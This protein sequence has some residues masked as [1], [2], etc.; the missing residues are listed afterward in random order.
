MSIYA[1]PLVD[2]LDQESLIPMRLYREHCFSF[3]GSYIKDLSLLGRDMKDVII[4]D[5][6]PNASFFHNENAVP[7]RN[8]S[9]L[10]SSL[11]GARRQDSNPE[12]REKGHKLGRLSKGCLGTER[13]LP[14]YAQRCSVIV[15]SWRL[16]R[17]IVCQCRPKNFKESPITL[18]GPISGAK[19]VDSKKAVAI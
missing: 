7:L 15:S 8:D 16:V 1:N 11:S 14:H 9:S 4:V 12:I 2:T 10:G 18:E 19:P 13:R 5:N 17:A 6:S 3:Q